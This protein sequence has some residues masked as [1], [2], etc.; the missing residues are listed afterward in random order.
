MACN[1]GRFLSPRLFLLLPLLILILPQVRSVLFASETTQENESSIEA[2][3]SLKVESK[4]N[5]T[6]I[7]RKR[8]LGSFCPSKPSSGYDRGKSR[9][10]FY[11][12]IG[13]KDITLAY[14]GKNW[15]KNDIKLL[16][17]HGFNE[18]QPTLIYLHAYT[19]S[20]RS[21]WLL[22]I[23]DSY[24]EMF[25][26]SIEDEPSKF[27]LM[28]FDW[29]AY[30]RLQYN[31]AAS[32][33]PHLG[34]VLSQFLE[35]LATEYSYNMKQ[36]QIVSYSL[37]THIAGNAGRQMSFEN[38]I[39]KIVAL[40]PTGVCFHEDVAYA[41][42]YA[43]RPTDADFV[44]AKHYDVGGLGSRKLIGGLDVFING[45]NN[46]PGRNKRE[47][48]TVYG[49]N[50]QNDDG[51]DGMLVQ[52]SSV[53]GSHARAADHESQIRS[54]DCQEVAYSCRSYSGF[55]KG[56]C[57][58][59][60]SK[61][62]KCYFINTLDEMLINANTEYELQPAS[63]YKPRTKMY[64]KT[65]AKVYCL[66]HY[67]LL[68]RMK[69]PVSSTNKKLLKSGS[70]KFDLGSNVEVTPRHQL[71]RNHQKFTALMTQ[72]KQIELPEQVKVLVDS[73][74]DSN[75]FVDAIQSVELNYMSR[76]LAKERA[77]GSAKYCPNPESSNKLNKC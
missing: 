35:R 16:K 51:D 28:F 15:R 43:L 62:N 37:S 54:D 21:F 17:K 32:W 50:E 33:V 55:L 1:C 59:C 22:N 70:V 14:A 56:E 20:S 6:L 5:V 45:G 76:A 63:N 29:S 19:Q 71:K 42:E 65:G 9:I 68:I 53:F 47:S 31:V 38:R 7:R 30:S 60:G 58:S 64:I 23:R 77:Q 46:Q 48:E 40:D 57:A 24:N 11:S 3:E 8:Q 27:N 13:R 44:V 73:E 18:S 2:P 69:D 72:N 34:K 25:R 61:S 75:S 49:E 10:N 26:Q 36:M 66:H 67:Q 39:G 41:R 12:P 74:S 4:S 52:G